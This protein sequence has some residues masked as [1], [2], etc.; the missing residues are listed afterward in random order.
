M[1]DA[2]WVAVREDLRTR[3]GRDSF[4]NWIEQLEFKRI[5]DQCAHFKVPSKFVANWVERSFGDAIRNS[6]W[7]NGGKVHRFD[8]EVQ[9]PKISSIPSDVSA[10]SSSNDLVSDLPELPINRL[11]ERFKF[12]RFVVGKSNELAFNAA[13][14]VALGDSVAFNP[15][16]LYSGVGLGKTHLMQAIAWEIQ[17]KR[18]EKRVLFISAE[19]FMYRFVQALRAKNMQDFKEIFRSVDVLLVDDVQ[20]IAGKDSTQ[21]EFFYTFNALIEQSKQIIISADRA[22]GDIQ[23]I[24]DRVKSRLQWG[25]MVDIHSADYELRLGILHTKCEFLR[26]DLPNV[27]IEEGVLEF[28]AQK[29]TS[30]VRVLEGALTRLFAYADLSSK[31]V[32]LDLAYDVLADVLRVS[33]SKVTIEQIIKKTAEFHN[34]RVSEVV[35]KRRM[36]SIAKPRQIAMYLAKRMTTKSLPDIGL[37]FGGRDHTTVIHSVKK[38]DELMRHDSETAEIIETLR[39][40]IEA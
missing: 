37:A 8:F 7:H 25:L 30:N 10:L 16:F 1:E 18:P 32:S 26:R 15:L 24:E 36:Q 3:V 21:D 20:F 39:R 35:G 19:Q 28:L 31:S 38:I 5:E 34:I 40:Q 23:G 12:E 6:F 29:I 13:R 11:D 33:K 9:K 2:I 14:R 4:R 27:V 17:E 22:P